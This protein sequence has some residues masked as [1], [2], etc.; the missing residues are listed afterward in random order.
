AALAG[1]LVGL[2][3]AVALARTLHGMLFTISPLDPLTYAGV[4]VIMLATAAAASYIPARR[5]TAVDP[6]SALR[7]G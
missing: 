6:V 3:A 7:S 2:A 4:A 1:T 5:A